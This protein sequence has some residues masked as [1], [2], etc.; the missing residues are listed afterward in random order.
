MAV[1]R[2][3][4]GF[5]ITLKEASS[6]LRFIFWVILLSG[7]RLKNDLNMFLHQL[8]ISV[9]ATI[10]TWIISVFLPMK[11]IIYKFNFHIMFQIFKLKYEFIRSVLRNDMSYLLLISDR[12]LI[13]HPF[14]QINLQLQTFVIIQSSIG[15]S[16]SSHD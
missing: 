4:R 7:Y 3:D 12:H 11:I 6:Y 8:H 13:R 16:F 14:I 1:M 15:K 9:I 10:F 5:Q 2:R